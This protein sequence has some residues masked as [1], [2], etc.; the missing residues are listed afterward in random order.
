MQVTE[1]N[2][3]LMTNMHIHT[4]FGPIPSSYCVTAGSMAISPRG[5]FVMII[6][7]IY[8]IY[9]VYVI[10]CSFEPFTVDGTS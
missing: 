1:L 4:G 7:C 3:S 5:L 10:S 6:M 9:T 8:S 2:G